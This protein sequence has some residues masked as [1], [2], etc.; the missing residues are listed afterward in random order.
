MEVPKVERVDLAVLE[1]FIVR[2][3][4][5]TYVGNGTGL[6]PYRLDSHD[7]QFA[8]GAWTYHDSYFGGTDFAG[9]ETVYVE[10][11]A[12]WVMNYFGRILEPGLIDGETAGQVIK[13]SLTAMY[14]EG[15]FLGGYRHETGAYTYHDS[16]TGSVA[17]FAGREWIER[18]GVMVYEL[19]YHGGLVR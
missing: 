2:A 8:D 9:Q 7:L 16:S 10:R 19:V 18:D 13:E 6:L 3:K 12:V 1:R 14:R 17:W 4:A 5:A 15:R 11:T